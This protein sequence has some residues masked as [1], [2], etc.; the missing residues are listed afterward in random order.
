MSQSAK[1]NEEVRGEHLIIPYSI[2]AE[3]VPFFSFLEGPA[4]GE[5]E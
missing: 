4:Q 3:M 2:S 5:V 1:V